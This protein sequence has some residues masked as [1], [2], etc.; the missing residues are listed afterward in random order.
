MQTKLNSMNQENKKTKNVAVGALLASRGFQE[1]KMTLPCALGV[2]DEGKSFLFDLTKMPHVLIGESTGIGKSNTM[3]AIMASLLQ[4]K[5]PEELKL[6]LIDP[7]RVEFT[8][9]ETLSPHYL[10]RLPYLEESIITDVDDAVNAL[11]SLNELM[12]ERYMLLQQYDVMN[13]KDYNNKY[14]SGEIPPQDTHGIMPYYVVVID[15]VGAFML[16]AGREF[17]LPLVSLAQL[18]RA[19]GIHIIISSHRPL[20]SVFPGSIKAN[21]PCRIAFRTATEKDSRIIM[22]NPGAEQLPGIGTLLFACGGTPILIHGAYVDVD[23][24]LPAMFAQ[25][26]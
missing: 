26:M 7:K 16:T 8:D 12:H 9:Y 18:S 25:L 1:T 13:I 3:H 10:A 14:K 6:V 11:N 24:Y 2:T 23:N 22:D 15:E 17:E 5:S 21:F 4:K 20:P 19:V